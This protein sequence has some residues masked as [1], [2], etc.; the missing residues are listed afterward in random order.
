[1]EFFWSDECAGLKARISVF[2]RD[3]LSGDVARRD[4][5]QEFSREDWEKCARFGIQGL[6]IPPE[7][8]GQ[9]VDILEATAGMEALGHGCRDNGLLLALN[10]QMWTVQM[11]ILHHGTEEQKR[12]Y[13]PAL[14]RGELIA[15]H[16]VTEAE[17]GSDAYS[18]RLRAEK[19]DGGYVLNGEK[20]MVTLAPVADLA[21]VFASS[22][23]ELEKWGISIFLVESDTPGFEAGPVREKMGLRTVPFG[24]LTFKDCFVPESQRLGPE[25]AG[26][27]ISSNSLEWERSCMLASQLGAMERQLE[28]AIRFAR[29]RRQFGRPIAT[30]Q[31]VS[32]RLADMKVRLEAARLFVYRV[33]WLKSQGR[34]ATLEA[35]MAKLSLCEGFV[36]SSLDAIR[37]HG[38]RGYVT[39]QEVER[40]LR[41]SVGGLLYGGTSDIQRS[42]IARMLGL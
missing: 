29:E 30:F 18:L 27:S 39:D 34:R 37:T 2:A 13:L 7:Y 31:A 8:G 22:A 17:A 16:A 25:G 15:A 36:E 5:T 32:H 1:M 12:R 41:D 6:A 14:C 38:G 11:P 9:G 20:I 42:I 26:I 40:D 10:A 23:P 3:E 4:R 33:A 35:A 21:L 19:R 28:A 24:T